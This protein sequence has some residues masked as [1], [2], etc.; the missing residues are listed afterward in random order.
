MIKSPKRPHRPPS[1]G[2]K[3]KHLTITRALWPCFF[4][5]RQIQWREF[6]LE[7]EECRQGNPRGLCRFGELLDLLSGL[8]LI[9]ASNI[10]LTNHRQVNA[11]VVGTLKGP[12]G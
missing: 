10:P 3:Q 11:E 1:L 7:F 9:V 6:H 2:D 8:C 4:V 12:N 5:S